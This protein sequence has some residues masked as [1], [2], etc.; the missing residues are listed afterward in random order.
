MILLLYTFETAH[1]VQYGHW[2]PT[3]QTPT[4]YSSSHHFSIFFFGPP[5]VENRRANQGVCGVSCQLVFKNSLKDR[6]K[7]RPDQ[8]IH[9]HEMKASI[10]MAA[11]YMIVSLI[12]NTIT[13][14]RH[15]L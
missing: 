11:R 7:N 1:Y 14:S 8:E 5:D 15:C 3:V 13:I 10:I 2:L 6:Q 9:Y 12:L 4:F